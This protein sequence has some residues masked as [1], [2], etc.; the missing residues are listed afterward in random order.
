MAPPP[1]CIEMSLELIIG[2]MFAGKSSAIIGT[3]RRNNF[4]KRKTL[5]VTNTIDTRYAADAKIM[6]HDMESY[7]A[8]AVDNLMEL[9]LL[10]QYHNADCV[11]IEEAQF[12]P[13]LLDFVLYAVEVHN[14]QVICVGLDGDTQR[15]SFGQ[16]LQLIPYADDVKKYASLC[17]QCHDGTKGIFTSRKDGSY[18]KQISVGGADQ[19][20]PLCRKHYLSQN[21]NKARL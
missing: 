3:I 1:F 17:N 11:I 19:Y 21:L 8:T 4:I 16:L 6:T 13:D 15:K 7:P 12:F 18:D 9:K 10:S 5:C 14:K 2:P 20:E